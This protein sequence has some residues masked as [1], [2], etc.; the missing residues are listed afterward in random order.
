MIPMWVVWIV[1]VVWVIVFLFWIA[2][3][4]NFLRAK[5]AH[6]DAVRNLL[7]RR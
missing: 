6:K 5:K 2:C 1:R 3:L 7:G 4:V